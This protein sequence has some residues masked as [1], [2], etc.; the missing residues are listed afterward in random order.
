M[1]DYNELIPEMKEWNN[2][3]GIDIEAWIGCVGDF[4]KAVGYSTILWPKFKEVNGCVVNALTPDEKVYDWI[5]RCPDNPK[6]V[7]PTMN[8]LHIMDL[9]YHDISNVNS[10]ILSY[11]GSVLKEI[12]E[13]KLKMDFPEKDIIVEFYKPVDNDDLEGYELTFYQ[14]ID[15]TNKEINC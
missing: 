9:H 2:G 10:E 15:E 4:Q 8:H 12:Y 6:A 11:L 7:E 5:K 13:C 1:P 3:K 14:K